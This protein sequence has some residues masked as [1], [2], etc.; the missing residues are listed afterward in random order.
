[1]L[2]SSSWLR[3]LYGRRMA[4]IIR[5]SR[6]RIL[7]RSDKG[8]GEKEMREGDKQK[9]KRKT[10]LPKVSEK[11]EAKEA[12]EA[13]QLESFL[14]GKPESEAASK[15]GHELDDEEIDPLFG[16][17]KRGINQHKKKTSKKGKKGLTQKVED[18]A[19][20]DL[21]TNAAVD[22]SRDVGGQ[23]AL[24]G[25]EEGKVPV[26]DDEEEATAVVRVAAVN[27][28]RKLRKEEGEEVVSGKDYVSRL[29][30]QHTVLN[31]GVSWAELPSNKKKDGRRRRLDSELGSDSDSEERENDFGVQNLLENNDDLVVKSS[32]SRLPQG[33]LELIPMRDGNGAEPSNAVV[34][35]VEFHR[36][37]QILMTAG[38]DKRLRFFQIDGKKNPKVESIFLEDFPIYKAAFIPDGSKVVAAGRRQYYFMYDLEAGRVERISPLIGR[39]EKSLESFEVSS[40]S[41]TVAF[42]GNEGYIMLCSLDSKQWVGNLKM[43]GS[44]RAVAFADDG[45]HLVSTG[46]DG[47]VYHWDL[48][49]RRCFH[50]GKDEGFIEMS[51]S[52]TVSPD[53]RL[54]ATGSGKGV[55]NIYN[56]EAFIGGVTRPIKSLM[57]LVTTVDN[58]KFNCDSQILAITSRMKKNAL[59]LVHIP[60]YTVFSNWPT[61][62]SPLG[63]VHSLDFS[64]GGGYLAVGNAAGRVLLY[65][66]KHY[67]HA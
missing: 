32:R 34:Q 18:N 11:I 14:F 15:Y 5:M 66:L 55:V 28:L 25:E 61:V 45:R 23:D 51:T 8:V 10:K 64:P 4:S 6:N 33:L 43:N 65:R 67:D 20:E 19:Q 30:A 53:S 1:V 16:D 40:D 56:R 9:R 48:R 37:A 50:K 35:S 17:E 52:L 42:L 57:N 27:R 22:R 44:V 63:Y 38:Y 36:N 2:P 31:R 49:T 54:F 60:S 21:V 13:A 62:Q 41:K 3:L 39:D 29:R 58:A 7:I 46:G 26:W 47:E 24:E 59:R 12:Q